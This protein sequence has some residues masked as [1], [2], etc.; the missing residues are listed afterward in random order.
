M[1]VDVL[2]ICAQWC[3]A[4]AL[5]P[6]ILGLV[7]A[8][9]ARLQGRRGPG[10][11]Q[12]YRDLRRLWGRSR[13]S[14]Q[15]HSI[16]YELA[17]L[18]SVSC[19]ATALLMLPAPGASPLPGLGDDAIVLVGLLAVGRFVLALSA[20]D[21]GNGFSLMGAARDMA[22]AVAAEG[23]FIVT[24]IA[25]ALTAAGT[26]L[27]TMGAAAAEP[28]AW[29]QV[30]RWSAIIGLGLVA[31][32]ETGRR[33]IDNPET[34]LELT[35]V[36]EGPLLEYGGRDLALLKWAAAARG[37]ILIYLLAVV[38]LPRPQGSVAGG[39]TLAA[40]LAAICLLTAVA[41]ST[42]AKMRILRVPAFLGAGIAVVLL[43]VAAGLWGGLA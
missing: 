28:E 14:P 25:L 21:T 22:F 23:L 42:Q 32:A 27:A 15:P 29:Q 4:A 24:I 19:V 31:L 16:A 20:W 18:V 41:E 26:G 30:I 2:T 37:L 9:I 13:I 6:L 33:P 7:Q 36:H 8:F 3:I 12:P 10:P 5:A 11:L 43:G 34:H 38:A 1:I 17:P 40:W 35:M 39:L